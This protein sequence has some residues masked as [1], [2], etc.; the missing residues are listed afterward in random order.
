MV[1]IAADLA[2][3]QQLHKE[4]HFTLPNDDPDDEFFLNP[5]LRLKLLQKPPPVPLKLDLLTPQH[6]DYFLSLISNG[7]ILIPEPEGVLSTETI[8]KQLESRDDFHLNHLLQPLHQHTPHIRFF[9]S[10]QAKIEIELLTDNSYGIKFS[11]KTTPSSSGGSTW[12]TMCILLAPRGLDVTAAKP[13]CQTL[14]TSGLKRA[15]IFDWGILDRVE[16]AF[17]PKSAKRG[18]LDMVIMPSAPVAEVQK[19]G[20]SFLGIGGR[21]IKPQSQFPLWGEAHVYTWV[22]PKDEVG[23]TRQGTLEGML[24]ANGVPVHGGFEMDGVKVVEVEEGG[25]YVA[26]G[27]PR[28]MVKN[29]SL[30]SMTRDNNLLG[31]LSMISRVTSFAGL[32][33]NEWERT[34]GAAE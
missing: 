25:N 29:S 14:G 17:A 6:M 12:N 20:T 10:G 2:A 7:L 8:I 13:W 4:E 31:S 1:K 18:V 19:R 22:V 28:G 15:E 5:S 24:R 9:N 32:R 21:S 23:I 30:D 11:H 33:E 16:H 3:L 34:R 27:V 26:R